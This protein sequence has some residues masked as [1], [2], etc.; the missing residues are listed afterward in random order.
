MQLLATATAYDFGYLGYLEFLERLELTVA[1]LLKMERSHGHFLN[2]YNTLNLEPLKPAYISTV[3]SGN[4]AG[5]LLTLKQICLEHITAP[6][7]NLKSRQGLSDT[8]RQLEAAAQT[9]E[10]L[11]HA[12]GAI[13][14][15]Q[16]Q[17]QIAQTIDH[18][19]SFEWNTV[20]EWKDFLTSL[21]SQVRDIRDLLDTLGTDTP[22]SK[23]ADV[24]DWL[25][26]ASHHVTEFQR[27]LAIVGDS[28]VSA[29]I[30]PDLIFRQREIADRSEQ[31]AMEMDFGFLFD[32]V[33]KIFVIGYNVAE[34]PPRQLSLRS[35]G[36]GIAFGKFHCH[37]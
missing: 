35:V 17:R 34:S 3:D 22:P 29:S 8:F 26:C 36:I 6:V 24:R 32:E 20:S 2:W 25:N 21:S 5:H 9:V 23:L 30:N 14:L 15:T 37:R 7:V 33:R 27:D 1:S 13:T 11:A 12:G 28:L 4:L 10:D 31:L 16:L 19:Q 18:I